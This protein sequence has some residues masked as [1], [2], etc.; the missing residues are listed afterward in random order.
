M[1]CIPLIDLNLYSF[2]V[3]TGLLQEA[4]QILGRGDNSCV[5]GVNPRLM[6]H[7]L[8]QGVSTV[9]SFKEHHQVLHA[10]HGEANGLPDLAQVL[11]LHV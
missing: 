4:V 1:I 9:L 6:C 8:L 2:K 10:V 11:I 3:L 5:L 7:F